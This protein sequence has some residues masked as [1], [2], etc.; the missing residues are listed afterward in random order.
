MKR[1]QED[2]IAFVP[3]EIRTC[4]GKASLPPN[5]NSTLIG[6]IELSIRCLTDAQARFGILS[7]LWFVTN[8]SSKIWILG[9]SSTFTDHHNKRLDGLELQLCSNR[10]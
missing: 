7:L 4:Y 9:I 1:E 8:L 3:L 10:E 2:L 6:K 5:S